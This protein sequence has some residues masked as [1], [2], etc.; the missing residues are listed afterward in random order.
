MLCIKLTQAICDLAWAQFE[1]KKYTELN[2]T[3]DIL[4]T[5]AVIPT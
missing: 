1:S 2:L 3:R 5:Y 4:K